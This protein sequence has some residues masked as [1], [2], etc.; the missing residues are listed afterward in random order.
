[1]VWALA[2]ALCETPVILGLAATN[3]LGVLGGSDCGI[4][5]TSPG[6]TA[7]P[8]RHGSE[9]MRQ[10]SDSCTSRDDPAWRAAESSGGP[11]AIPGEPFRVTNPSPRPT[12]TFPANLSA[13]HPHGAPPVDKRLA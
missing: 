7:A 5:Q 9:R 6:A 4:S 12:M 8:V 3:I 10:A 13:A 1:M 11:G 2:G